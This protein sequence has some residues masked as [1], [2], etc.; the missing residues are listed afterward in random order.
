[1]TATVSP[2]PAPLVQGRS[3]RPAVLW[4]LA[5]VALLTAVGAVVLAVSSD[6]VPDPVARALLFDWIAL[7]FVG[8]GLIAWA[9]RPDSRFGPLMVAAGFAVWLSALEWANP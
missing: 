9:R 2:G 5:V 4:V 6:H 1:M 7:P 3:P 8:A